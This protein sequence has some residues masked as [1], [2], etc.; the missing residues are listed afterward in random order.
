MILFVCAW[1]DWDRVF[2]A[3]N[4]PFKDEREFPDG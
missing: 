1:A 3:K 4:E 2:G